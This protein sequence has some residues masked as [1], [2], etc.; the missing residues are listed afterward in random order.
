[1]NLDAVMVP[2]NYIGS[3]NINTYH[4]QFLIGNN[5]YLVKEEMKDYIG[6]NSSFISVPVPPHVNL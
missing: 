6:G 4:R 1:M 5:E 3:Y 2:E